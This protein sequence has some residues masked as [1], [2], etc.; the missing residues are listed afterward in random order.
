MNLSILPLL[1]L[2][3]AVWIFAAIGNNLSAAPNCFFLE[4][5]DIIVPLWNHTWEIC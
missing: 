2:L 4:L 3:K 5:F 1:M